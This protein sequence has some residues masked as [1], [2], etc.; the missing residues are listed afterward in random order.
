MGLE[1]RGFGTRLTRLSALAYRTITREEHTVAG[2]ADEA[3]LTMTWSRRRTLGKG[4][5]LRGRERGDIICHHPPPPRATSSS[6]LPK[7][8][9]SRD[10]LFLISSSGMSFHHRALLHNILYPIMYAIKIYIVYEPA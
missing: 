5:G 6:L 8:K 2:K 9:S 4:E 3:R 7:G 10:V 1:A